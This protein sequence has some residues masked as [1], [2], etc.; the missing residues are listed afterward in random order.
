MWTDR[1][2]ILSREW[3]YCPSEI[4]QRFNS[5]IE[6]LF[7]S[8]FNWTKEQNVSNYQG[9]GETENE[10]SDF[11]NLM[12]N[13]KWS[14]QFK[15]WTRD[16]AG[17]ITSWDFIKDL[18]KLNN[19]LMLNSHNSPISLLNRHDDN[20]KAH[21]SIFECTVQQQC[22]V[23]DMKFCLMIEDRLIELRLKVEINEILSRMIQIL[24]DKWTSKKVSR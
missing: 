5:S 9:K 18:Q 13:V 14:F 15:R 3:V 23:F 16:F 17:I 22:A 8:F 12:L 21:L 4:R 1:K 19:F 6:S 7:F 11:Y 10:R 20:R 24:N 2:T